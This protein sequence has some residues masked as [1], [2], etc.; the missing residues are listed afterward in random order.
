MLKFLYMTLW[1]VKNITFRY[2]VQQSLL[3]NP[4]TGKES[5]AYHGIYPKQYNYVQ[6]QDSGTGQDNVLDYVVDPEDSIVFSFTR[7]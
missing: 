2:K 7:F 5:A 3:C 4:F 6:Q 1:K